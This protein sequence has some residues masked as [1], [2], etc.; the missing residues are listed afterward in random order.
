MSAMKRTKATEADIALF[1]LVS[2]NG[3]EPY[4]R[5]LDTQRGLT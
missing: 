5:L 2:R 3:A 1:G 4:P